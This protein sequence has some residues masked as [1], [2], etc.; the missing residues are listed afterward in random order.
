[1]EKQQSFLEDKNLVEELMNFIDQ[2][3]TA[4]QATENEAQ[5]LDAQGFTEIKRSDEWSLKAGDKKYVRVGDAALIAFRLGEGK[6]SPFH[7]L[8]SHS[9]SPS[10]RLK[11]SPEM[12]KEGL[13][14][15]N[16]E[17]YGGPIFRTWLDRPLSIAGRVIIRDQDRV[18]SL[19]VN[20]DKDLLT[21]PSLAI[22]MDRQV[23]SEGE[24]K[25][26]KTLIPI[27]GIENNEKEEKEEGILAYIASYM[28]L[29]LDS[30]IDFDLH[31]YARE[32]G[33]F[34]GDK[35]E[36]FS[37][38]R[39]DNL[40]MAHA[41]LK[42]LGEAEHAEF[43]QLVVVNDNEEI[44]SSTL[45]G[46]DSALLRDTLQRIVFALG[47]DPEDF[48]QVLAKSF[49]I[50]ADQAHAAHPNYPEV[51]DPTNRPRINQGPVI[52]LAANKSYNTDAESA[53]RLRIL[54]ESLDVP[55]QTFHNHSDRRGGS[56]IG[57]LTEKWTT[58]QG[59]DIGNP[60][61][62][63][64]SVRELAGVQDHAYMVKLLKGFFAQADF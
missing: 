34:I 63:M 36:F 16:V 23:N 18:K 40:A 3:P 39:I 30:I 11:A 53:A 2:S 4:Y 22:H 19:L 12:R 52:K 45:R 64:H 21:I 61:L 49:I 31:L 57:P 38:G 20:I 7:I 44:G 56:T 41:Q 54:A 59:V 51:A 26:Q 10:L 13:K 5:Y 47:G 58:I 33:S 46:A 8:G 37:I 1:M 28:D 48:Y 27:Y 42:A 43:H 9:D 55:L 29:D 25:P 14:S 15:L 60:M 24:I 17:V 35:E 50:S 62:A 6:T 32:K